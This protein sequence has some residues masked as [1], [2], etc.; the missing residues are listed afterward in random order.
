MKLSKGDLRLSRQMPRILSDHDERLPPSRSIDLVTEGEKAFL[1]V[2]KAIR[3][4][5]R[6]KAR[7]PD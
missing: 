4:A 5:H 2:V 6:R 3:V 7:I 1:R